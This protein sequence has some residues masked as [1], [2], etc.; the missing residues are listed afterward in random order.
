MK[1]NTGWQKVYSII[2]LVI[3][4]S[5][6]LGQLV[7]PGITVNTIAEE[8]LWKRSLIERYREYKFA[9]GDRIFSDAIIGQEGWLFYIGDMSI[10]NYQQTEPI[11]VSNI[12]KIVGIFEKM[13]AEVKEYGGTLL[14][15]IPPDKSTIYPQY[16]PDEIQ[17]IGTTTSLDRLVERVNKHGDFRLLDLRPAFIEA[18]QSLQL[19]YKTDTHWNCFGAY[20]AYEEI[21]SSLSEDYPKLQGYSLNDFEITILEEEK[22][23]IA[24][25]I[26]ADIKENI[27]SL[28]PRFETAVFEDIAYG[29]RYGLEV[30]R[31]I[32]NQNKRDQPSLMIFHDSFYNACLN[33]FIEPTFGRTM[34]V[35]Y[36]DLEFAAMLE[37]IEKEKPE[38]VI[39]EFV[40]RFMD[41]IIWHMYEE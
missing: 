25:M 27:M 17:V 31:V 1:S 19:Y 32:A 10:R 7:S 38:I 5:A 13:S 2:F 41:F 14:V 15:V 4:F 20:Y 36:K 8:Y 23:D 30:L 9:V 21:I 35:A 24:K 40:E 3:V 39:V 33:S 34:T 16:M 12:K 6:F 29:S 26:E 11:N 37:L 22:Q 28:S 18:S